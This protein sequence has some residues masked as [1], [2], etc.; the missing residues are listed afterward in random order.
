VLV[1]IELRARFD[2]EANI[3]L[4]NAL[5]AAGVQVVYGVVGHKT[6]AKMSMV[7][8]REGRKLQ[9]F[10]HLGT[11]N[12][13]ARTARLYTDFG[14]FTCDPEIGE[15]IQKVF[16][17][18]TAMGREGKLRK[19]LQSPFTLHKAILEMIEV[20]IDNAEEGKPAKIMAKMNSLNEPAIIRALY[21]ASRA[22][23]K[24]ELI[25]RGHCGL[26]P[27][28]AEVSENIRV[29]SIVGRFLEHTRVF[30]FEA[31]GEQNVYLSSADW[32]HR[33]FFDRVETC[34]P[35]TDAKMKAR[36]IR[37]SFDVYLADNFQAWILQAD[38]TYIRETPG[39]SQRF[40]AQVE[41]LDN[42]SVL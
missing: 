42:L 36:V 39:D 29:R 27:G 15:D 6:H 13:H 21:R 16:Q 1:V 32:M 7:I 19:I 33:N 10:V 22:G 28:I 14:L 18:L 23:V 20:E 41:L 37:E 31:M 26:R 24:V 38:G 25:V 9:R 11:G 2:E 8:R 17:Q 34:F 35:I 40:C 12:Y 3:E 30:Y 5:Q 4:A